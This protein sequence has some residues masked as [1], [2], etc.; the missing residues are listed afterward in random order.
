MKAAQT[1]A[2]A[3]PPSPAIATEQHQPPAAP[4][5]PAVSGP[6]AIGA[7]GLALIKRFES[8][9]RRQA[10]GCLAAYADPGTGGAPWTIGWGTTGTDIGPETVWT[11]AQCDARLEHDITRFAADVSRALGRAPTS[12]AQFDAMVCFHYNTGAIARAA[13][14]RL[15]CAGDYAG[16]AA[17]F[18]KWV[19]AG[20]KL[21]PG[22][23][24]RRAAERQLY[25]ST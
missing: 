1:P 9:A 11:Q 10:D 24:R 17:E 13:L 5:P 21:L 22:L 20:G 3:S 23:V 4:S 14:T 8:C 25:L 19:H 16:A 2:P 12:Q 6:R 7:P 15:H 18:G